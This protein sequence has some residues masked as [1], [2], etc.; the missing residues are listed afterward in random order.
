MTI[1]E[2]LRSIIPTPPDLSRPSYQVYQ[3][4]PKMG[5]HLSGFITASSKRD[6]LKQ[7]KVRQQR[8]GIADSVPVCIVE[9]D[10]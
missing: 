3:K 10:T 1:F 6:A 9:A 2:R 7:I 8:V 5:W 4:S